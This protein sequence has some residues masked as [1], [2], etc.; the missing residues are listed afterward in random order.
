VDERVTVVG[1]EEGGAGGAAASSS[2]DENVDLREGG[3]KRQTKK[4]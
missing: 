4:L 3:K 2:D 1:A